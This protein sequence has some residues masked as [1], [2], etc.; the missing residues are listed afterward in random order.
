MALL[1][2]WVDWALKNR[3]VV[4]LGAALLAAFG[5]DSARKLHMDAVP[6]VT[7]V[8]VAIITS[9]PALSPVEVEQYITAPVER[10]MAG[11]PH[12]VELRSTSK[13][14]L[15][16]VTLVFSDDTNIYF[17]RQLV[18][19]RM[20][21]AED[22]IPPRYGRPEMGPI[23]TGLG[24]VFQ[25]IVRGEGHS[26]ME[27]EELLDWYIGPQLRMVPGIVEVNSFGGENKQYQVLVDPARLQAQGLSLQ[28]VD[29]ALERSNAN[30]GGGYIE[31]QR[32]H[33]V[34]GSQGLVRG[35]QDLQNVVIGATPH[36]TPVLLGMV[37]DVQLGPRL[38]RGAASVDGQGEVVIGVAMMLMG[39]NART[40]TEGVKARL[41]ELKPS[42]P[43]GVVIEPFYDR[44]V[45]VNRTIRTVATN[46][47]EG[48]F[49]VVLVLFVLLGGIRAGLVAAVTIP[50]SMLFA[51]AMMRL[52]GDT[53][54]LMSLGAIDFGLIV[55][56]SVIIVENA[57]RRLHE[58]S[59]LA[60]RALRDDERLA[61][62]RE[63]TL[64]VRGATVFGELIIAI[65]YVPI[66]AL[67]GVE[68]KLFHP[69]ATTVLLAL[70][71]AFILSL[72]VVPVLCSLILRPQHD[73]QATFILRVADRVYGVLLRGVTRFHKSAV[74]AA[75]TTLGIT[76][77]LFTQ[78]GAEFVPTLDEG[79][80]LIEARRLPGIA[81][82][83]SVATDTR[84]QA[85][86]RTLPEVLHVV[87]RA[88]SPELATD[89]MG[90]E[91]SDN[92]VVLKPRHEWREG[93]LKEQLAA[94]IAALIEE[95]VP[96]VAT[97]ISQP[98]EMRT[99]ELVAGVKSDVAAFVYGPDL[100]V[101][102]QLGEQVTRALQGLDG[103]A[104]V[105]AEQ[106]A[107]LRYLSIT[108]DRAR[109]AR[110]GLTVEDVNLLTES[111]AVGHTA[112]V[113]F[114]GE[115]RFELVLRMAHTFDGTLDT[116]ASLPLK[117]V[118]G[119][120]V[121]LGD[122]ASVAFA[123]GPAQVSREKL[124]RRLTV[125]FNVRGGDLMRVVDHAQARVS[126]AVALPPGYR[127]EWGGQFRH[128]TDARDRLKLVVPLALA[129]ILLLLWLALG[130]VGAA[131]LIFCAVPF[132]VVGGVVALWMRGLPFSISAGVG[133][134]A[135][136]GVAVLNGL[137]LMSF[138]R[139]LQ[140]A[141]AAAGDAVNA[142]AISRLR[143]VL[144]TAA[145][146][147]L[148]FVPMALSHAPGAEVQR[149]LAT[150]VIG[151]LISST[152]LTLLVLP[153]IH[154]LAWTLRSVAWRTRST[155]KQ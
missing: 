5:V 61:V 48:A 96:E 95:R 122:V 97:G 88:G 91:Q 42:L 142:A 15:S 16:V 99:N 146:A 150:V 113:V 23:S 125:E 85:A 31:H 123:E 81:L 93:L 140:R 36:G 80:L 28:D 2:A 155:C 12:T 69:M 53:G 76:A 52:R 114:E 90:L 25:F 117:S 22:A 77:W 46:L 129:F 134:I 66:L 59:R 89:P 4:L 34:I 118:S 49:L 137:V 82:S 43:R 41:E 147:A 149:P 112:G 47:L 9:A 45:L 108:P 63:A 1:T 21:E 111:L 128:F 13:Y 57:V 70:L 131:L 103:V 24:E 72:T 65:V 106:V 100:A 17:A 56:G 152:V 44:A 116:I 27:L 19:E 115:R 38:R 102:K 20:K 94:E 135:L 73:E 141:G 74:T 60:G 83:Q 32:E 58:A 14:G 75:I 10:A 144:M 132:S 127:I 29:S 145:V 39:E 104:D 120:M 68:G 67:G 55:D 3:A 37:A 84:M 151:G 109:L 64:E 136:S 6:D 40:V 79:D 101:L 62:V 86:I 133:F 105:R 107:G 33:F 7:N 18:M 11:L 153:A 30:A 143:P 78:L 51:I 87:S 50:L 119:Q 139:H 98:I 92:Y 138:A 124:S 121:P 35:V 110:Y 126:S 26:L 54:N 71:G 8:Q 130:S 154:R 148:G